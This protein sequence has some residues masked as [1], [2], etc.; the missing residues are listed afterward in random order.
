MRKHDANASHQPTRVIEDTHPVL[1]PTDVVF[2]QENGDDIQ[3]SIEL[4][5]TSLLERSFTGRDSLRVVVRTNLRTNEAIV[6]HDP[7]A[8]GSNGPQTLVTNGRDVYV[9]YKQSYISVGKIIPDKQKGCYNPPC[10]FEV[11]IYRVKGN[12]EGFRIRDGHVQAVVRDESG[13]LNYY[14]LADRKAKYPESS[15]IHLAR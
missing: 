4:R 12:L 8:S 10:I 5:P 3:Y 6:I 9:H 14:S 1:E 13:Q 2:V 15:Y 7:I 11:D